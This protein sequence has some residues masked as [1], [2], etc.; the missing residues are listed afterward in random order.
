MPD[1]ILK[2]KDLVKHYPIKG[3]ILRR[4]G[5][6]RQ[7]VDGVGFESS[8]ARPSAWSAS[9]AVASRPSGA[10]SCAWR[11]R[12]R[13]QRWFQG[14]DMQSSRR[15]DAPHATRHPDRLPG[16]HTSPNPAQDL[17]AT[18]SA[19][20]SRSTTWSPGWRPS[21]GPGSPREGRPQSRA[22]QPLPHQFSVV[23][24][25]ASASRGIALNPQSAHLRRAGLRPRRLGAGPGRQPDGEAAERAGSVLHLHRPR[26]LGRPASG[27]GPG[28]VSRQGSPNSGREDE[29][30][31]RQTHP[32]PAGALGRSLSPTHACGASANRSSSPAMCPLT[33]ESAVRLPSHTRCWRGPGP[34][35]DRGA[36]T[37]PA[38][39]RRRTASLRLP[40]REVPCRHRH[41]ERADNSGDALR[42]GHDRHVRRRRPRQ[43]AGRRGSDRAGRRCRRR[44]S[45]DGSARPRGRWTTPSTWFRTTFRRRP[46]LLTPGCPT[47]IP[48][49]PAEATAGCPGVRARPRRR[50]PRR[51][52]RR[53]AHSSSSWCSR[54][55]IAPCPVRG[56]E[57]TMI[58]ASRRASPN[59]RIPGCRPPQPSP[60]TGYDRGRRRMPT[61]PRH[62]VHPAGRASRIGNQGVDE[63]RFPRPRNVRMRTGAT[64]QPVP[65]RVEP[66]ECPSAPWLDVDDPRHVQ[67]R[68]GGEESSGRVRVG[69]GQ[70]EGDQVPRRMPRPGTGR[71]AAAVGSGS[72]S[73]VTTAN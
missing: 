9:P 13:A 54:G 47:P 36:R 4:H 12:P 2:A 24:V 44:F 40:L 49:G 29:V 62:A 26:P 72:A 51:R 32:T 38:S 57:M 66:V 33:G 34:V 10:S 27:P 70:D 1:V 56:R 60:G 48:P 11:N 30:Y 58:R 43:A 46:R 42:Q 35:P 28:H 19:S 14:R 16:S 15:R 41:H 52:R 3:G 20:R 64:V 39:R 5:R 73:D 53:G 45:A 6:L 31:D 17:S 68:I 59:D 55:G 23:S 71:S 18:S 8:R 61:S 67:G 63:R 25:S 50:A 22:H 37:H 7:T 69:L 21:G 65:D